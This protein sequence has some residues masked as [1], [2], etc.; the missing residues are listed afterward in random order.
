MEADC[1]LTS[2]HEA[3]EAFLARSSASVDG[4]GG[5]FLGME[6]WEP[7]VL[8]RDGSG[9]GLVCWEVLEALA[10]LLV[11]LDM[12]GVLLTTVGPAANDFVRGF[13]SVLEGRAG[14]SSPSPHTGAR[15]LG[16]SSSD[17]VLEAVTRGALQL[18]DTVEDTL[19][20]LSV[21]CELFLAGSGGGCFRVGK[22][23]GPLGRFAMGNCAV[24]LMV[25]SL[26]TLN[27][28]CCFTAGRLFGI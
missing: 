7:S 21:S 25:F 28:F 10:P 2:V 26:G 9:G 6:F 16:L 20:C 12:G 3:K 22:G 14:T 5:T 18:L 19:Y 13:A 15:T 11:I 27:V 23:G 17:F 1:L 8:F 4:I 24:V